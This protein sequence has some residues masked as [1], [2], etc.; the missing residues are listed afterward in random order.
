MI[1]EEQ[2]RQETDR[3]LRLMRKFDP[4]NAQPLPEGDVYVLPSNQPAV[5]ATL[6]VA[7]LTPVL[8]TAVLWVVGLGG[9]GDLTMAATVIGLL[10]TIVMVHPVLVEWRL[11][12][13]R[14][15]Y[16]SR[17]LGQVWVGQRTE[18]WMLRGGG[19]SP[20]TVHLERQEIST[21]Q[22]SWMSRTF[23]RNDQLVEIP[24]GQV[25]LMREGLADLYRIRDYWLGKRN[26][27]N[28]ATIE[29]NGHLNA[30]YGLLAN[31]LGDAQVDKIR[32]VVREEL[33]KA[34]A[35]L[36]QAVVAEFSRSFNVSSGDEQ[37][38]VKSS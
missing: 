13:I 21:P 2:S 3:V 7:L 11:R 16:A 17:R 27:G 31:G 25:I 33:Q 12:H 8:W 14:P 20:D 35:L 30:I 37:S 5:W 1:T 32:Q 28:E 19:S 22:T 10:I 29:S 38:D 26:Q 4:Q 6:W 34:L 15:I 24:S 36:P 9:G 18:P 23:F